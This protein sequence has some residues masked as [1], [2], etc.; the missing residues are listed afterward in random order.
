MANAK[1]TKWKHHPNKDKMVPTI[2]TFLHK[3]FKK[4]KGRLNK[5]TTK[6]PNLNWKYTLKRQRKK[7]CLKSKTSCYYFEYFNTCAE[8]IGGLWRSGQT[9]RLS[10]RFR[11]PV[12]F[13]LM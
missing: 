3:K 12:R 8:C 9:T 1:V 2:R 5:T 10:V 6:G 4:I 11:S 13:T 7:F